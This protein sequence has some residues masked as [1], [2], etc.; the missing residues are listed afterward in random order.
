M[1]HIGRILRAVR[2]AR[3][4]SRQQ[5]ARR[6]GYGSV[7]K[8]VR[9]LALIEATGAVKSDLL[10][11]LLEVLQL[12]LACFEDMAECLYLS[13]RFPPIPPVAVEA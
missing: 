2:E 13:G 4:L 9:R 1:N 12:D 5:V 7:R 8:G 6:L 10:V 3:G 11:M